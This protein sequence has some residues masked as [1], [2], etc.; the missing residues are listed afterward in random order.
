MDGK[1]VL[2]RGAAWLGAMGLGRGEEVL[3][4]SERTG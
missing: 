2:K 3:F 4:R 1:P